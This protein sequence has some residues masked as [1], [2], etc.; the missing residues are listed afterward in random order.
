M[1]AETLEKAAVDMSGIL[2]KASRQTIVVMTCAGQDLGGGD[3]TH[4]LLVTAIQK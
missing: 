2:A 4:R 1:S 3:A